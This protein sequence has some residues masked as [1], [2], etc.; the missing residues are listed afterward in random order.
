MPRRS[1]RPSSGPAIGDEV[2]A[3]VVDSAVAEPRLWFELI[4]DEKWTPD[5]IAS[6]FVTAEERAWVL[7]MV[8]DVAWQ[9]KTF[10]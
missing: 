1:R 9:I 7:S 2:E 8:S 5:V 10:A 4:N 6:N 3:F